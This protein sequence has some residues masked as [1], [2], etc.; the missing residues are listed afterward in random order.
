MA[1]RR[2][3]EIMNYPRKIIAGGQTGAYRGALDFV[4]AHDIEHGGRCP[5]RRVAEDDPIPTR[6]QLQELASAE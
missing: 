4:I 5:C 6:Y 2:N 1:G 3:A